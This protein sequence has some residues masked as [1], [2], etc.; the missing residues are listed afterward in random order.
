MTENKMD[1]WLFIDKPIGISSFSVIRKIRKKLNI[2]KIGHAGTLDPFATGALGIAIGE[3]TKSIDYLSNIKEYEFNITF[4]ESKTT[5]DLEG[6]RMRISGLGAKVMRKF[7]VKTQSLS[8]EDALAAFESDALDAAEFYQPAIDFQ[9]GLHEMANNYYFPSWHQPT[10]LFEMIINLDAWKALPTAE[11]VQLETV[12]GDNIRHSLAQSEA[13]QFDA[14]KRM[15]DGGV[16]LQT[17][18]KE[19]LN[20]LHEAWRDVIVKE[21]LENKE[22]GYV[23]RSQQVFREEFS[24]WH[25]L[26]QP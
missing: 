2:K 8:D 5:E 21:T 24:I 17:W 15:V 9:L 16:I 22:F 18:P 11:K 6:L 1:G 12:C 25:E 3:A 7:G 26:T 4:G 13:M 23:W 14:L 20:K 19:V 10:T